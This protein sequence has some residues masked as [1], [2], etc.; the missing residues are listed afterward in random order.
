MEKPLNQDAVNNKKWLTAHFLASNYFSEK[1]HITKNKGILLLELTF[2]S[3]SKDF[4][5]IWPVK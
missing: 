5:K 4:M 3:F 2:L 1:F